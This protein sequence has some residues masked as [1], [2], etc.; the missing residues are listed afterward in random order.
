[1]YIIQLI[2]NV[3]LKLSNKKFTVTFITAAYIG[4]SQQNF[5]ALNANLVGLFKI[6][7]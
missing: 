3:S 4:T 2:L 1:M 6:P 7:F 5:H